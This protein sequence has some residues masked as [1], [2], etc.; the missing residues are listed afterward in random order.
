MQPSTHPTRRDFLATLSAGSLGA[1]AFGGVPLGESERPFGVVPTRP[2]SRE[3]YLFAP[4]LVY[5]QTGSL[6]PCSRNVVDATMRAW[7]ELE[8]NPAPMAYGQ[9]GTLGAAE[10]VRQQAADFLGCDADEIAITRSTTDGMNAVA[11]GLRLTAGDRILTTDQEH[12]GGNMGWLYLAQHHGVQ[13]DVVPLP[14]EGGDAEAI[15]SLFASAITAGTRVISVSHIVSGT[16]LRMPIAELSALARSRDILCVVDG[17][18]GPGAVEVDVKALGCHAYA[19][20]GHKWLMAPKGTGLLYLSRELG[21]R[22]V[23]MQFQDGRKYYNHSSGVG[24]LPGVVG[25]GVALTALSTAGMG[26]VEQHNLQLRD[27]CYHALTEISGLKMVSPPPGPLSSPM[28]TFSIP[29]THDNRE[30]RI[31]LADRHD[32]IV[33]TV[34]NPDSN[35][36]RLSSH[37]FNTEQDVDAALTVLRE[38]FG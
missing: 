29:A 34:T 23:P 36:I 22:I 1:V 13:V 8:T 21:E 11:Q 20:S 10:H 15:V 32:M 9:G 2:W 5:L 19:T 31:Y 6:G 38:E 16:G 33:K 37:I 28:V 35:G 18:Q 3:D 12:E 17:A 26:A 7:Y 27:R 4:G 30:F 25:L 24:N 14:R